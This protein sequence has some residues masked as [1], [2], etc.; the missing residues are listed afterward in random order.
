MFFVVLAACSTSGVAASEPEPAVD[1]PTK[2]EIEQEAAAGAKHVLDGKGAKWRLTYS[3]AMSGTLHGKILTSMTLPN[4]ISVQG[5]AMSDDMRSQ[6]SREMRLTILAMPGTEL[7]LTKAHVVLDDGAVCALDP[8]AS[9][10]V[11]VADTERKTFRA[12]A[13]GALH[14]GAEKKRVTFEASMNAAP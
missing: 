11:E 8:E 14:C 10:T 1:I 7:Q 5:A 12:S 2:Q 6:A 4:S 13:S 3:G 9:Q